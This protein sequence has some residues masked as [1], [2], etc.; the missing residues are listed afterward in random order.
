MPRYNQIPIYTTGS[1]ERN[2]RAYST[3]RYPQIPL[4]IN[5]VYVISQKGDRFDILAQ[6]YYSR[7]DYWWI[8]SIANENLPQNSLFLPEGQQ[9]RIPSNPEAIYNNFVILNGG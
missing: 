7:S 1:A 8:I 9:I 6:K 4:S 2:F 3:T 5:D